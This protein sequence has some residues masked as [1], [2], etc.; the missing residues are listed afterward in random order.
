[1]ASQ[2]IAQAKQDK[3]FEPVQEDAINAEFKETN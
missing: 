1:V 2:A 3:P